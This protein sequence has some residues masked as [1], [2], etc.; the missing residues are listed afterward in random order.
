MTGQ[1]AIWWLVAQ[2]FGLAGL[3]LAR[4]L[5]RALPDRGYAFAKTLGLLLAGYLAWLVAMLGLAPFGAALIV[6]S[7]LAV[8]AIGLFVNREQRTKLALERS[9]GNREQKTG[10]RLQFSILH[11]Q[12]SIP[13]VLAYEALFAAALVFLAL[14]R[15]RD[16]DG[17]VGPNPWNTERPMDY[18]LFNAIRRSAV[19]PPHDPWLSGYSINYY[20]FGYMLMAAVSLL[21]GLD[22]AVGYNLALALI[23]A[24]TALGVAGI[25]YN[26]IALTPHNEQP[27]SEAQDTP[28]AVSS[29]P[30]IAGMLAAAVLAVILVLFAANQGGALQLITGTPMAVALEAPDLGRAIVNGVGPRAPLQLR[31]TFKGDYFDG[32]SVITPTSVAEAAQSFNYWNSTRAVWDTY[33]Q[34]GEQTRHYAITEFPFFSFW[35]G[36]MHPHVMALPFGLLAIALALQTAAR[37]TAPAF[38]MGRRGWLE[39]AL[40]GIVLGSLYAINS[41]DFPTY[42]LLFLG[43]LLILHVRLGA[44]LDS[45]LADDEALDTTQHATTQRLP[46]TH[47]AS[48]LQRVWW[49]HYVGQAGMVIIAS[50]IMLTPFHL[51]FRSLVARLEPLINVP[52]VAT[53]TRTIGIVT[54]SRTTLLNFLVIFGL[55]LLPLVVYVF[56]QRRCSQARAARAP[57]SWESAARALPWVGLVACVAGPLIGFPMLVLLPLALYAGLLAVERTDQPATAF[58]L[59]GFAVGCLICFGTDIVYIRDVFE[60]LSARLNTIFKFYYQ[61]WLIWGTLAGYALWWLAARRPQTA[62]EQPTHHASRITHHASRLTWAGL[63]GGL[64]VVLLAGA[65]VYPWLTAGRSLREKPSI[66][67]AGTTPREE[68]PGGAAAIDWLRANTSGSAVILEAVGG[69]YNTEGFG[70]VSAASGLATVLGWPGHEDQ[71]RGGDPTA[72]AQIGPRQEDVKTIYAT[73]SADEA[74]A[75]LKKYKVDY[76]YVGQLERNTFPP[77]SL[78]K[79]DQLGLPVFREG[80]VTIYHVTDQ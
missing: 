27:T 33:L 59:W 66:G 69:A 3:P 67:L 57:G 73:P 24:L 61:T 64:F 36:D 21:S 72:R 44:R 53:I 14:L 35:L 15:S 76:V 1:I 34:D 49:R 56:A 4:F 71:W 12:F 39:L 26:L 52:I 32:T 47:Y 13:T 60:G 58:A 29:W 62:D 68:T 30:S 48:P 11:S 6:A 7:A 55:F 46:D 54:Q 38:A 10:A 8:G 65:L 37:L 41:W 23:F 9:E 25:V 19:F 63:F 70:G 20:Y 77:E 80:D 78:A 45:G 79:F 51:T 74:R 40:T 50:V 28:S 16:F 31:H 17:F 22:P 42:L 43:A 5:F 75:L 2:G 18:A